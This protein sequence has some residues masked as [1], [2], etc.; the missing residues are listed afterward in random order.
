MSRADLLSEIQTRLDL[1][2]AEVERMRRRFRSLPPAHPERGTLLR[3]LEIAAA[4][5][6]E[7]GS[8]LGLVGRDAVWRQDERT[9]TEPFTAARSFSILIITG[10][11]SGAKA[12]H[13]VWSIRGRQN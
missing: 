3:Q 2:E 9:T 11:H 5:A 13:L 7:L 4:V 12:P 1:T 6:G 8:L 10:K